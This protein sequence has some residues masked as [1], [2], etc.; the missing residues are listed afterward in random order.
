MSKIELQKLA[1]EH[2]AA[3]PKETHCHATSD[4]NVWLGKDKVWAERHAK[5]IG[6]KIEI[7]E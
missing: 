3:N 6:E 1:A 7:F 5:K 4:G 2:F